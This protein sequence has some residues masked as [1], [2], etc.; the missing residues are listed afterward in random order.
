[1]RNILLSLVFI[2]LLDQSSKA[3]PTEQL[4]DTSAPSWMRNAVVYGIK[5]SGFTDSGSY[6]SITKKLPELHELGINVIWLQPV[7]KTFQGGQGY[8]VTDFFALRNDLGTG[9]ELKQ[10]IDAAHSFNIKVIFDFVPNHSSL[11]HPFAEDIVARGPSSKYYDYYQHHNDGAPYSSY[12][13]Q[14]STGF[15]YYFWKNLVNLNYNNQQVQ[16]LVTNACRYWVTQYDIDGYR[17]DAVW[18][19]NARAPN[20]MQHLRKELRVLKPDF[21]MLAEDRGSDPEVFKKGF[22]AAYDWTNDTSWVSHWPWQYEHHERKSFTVFNHP[23]VPK[24]VALLKEALFA[25]SQHQDRILRFMENND[26]PR[27][28]ATH[29]LSQTKMAAKLLFA[30]PGIPLI[31]NGQETGVKAHPYSRRPIFL[32]Q[33]TIRQQD[34]FQ[35]FDIYRSLVAQRLVLKPFTSGNIKQIAVRGAAPVVAFKRWEGKDEIVVIINVDS[36]PVNA[37]L[38]PGISRLSTLTDLLTGEHFQ[39]TGNNSFQLPMQGYGV[40]WLTE[41]KEKKKRVNLKKQ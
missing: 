34:S 13:H 8:D 11:H 22:D 9:D 38:P 41:K 6:R 31:Y 18:A 12:Y 5:P 15:I 17:F 25:N 24:R 4:P 33:Y 28:A 26:L 3:S 1:M 35:L 10:L 40:R 7:F 16:Q 2:I 30:L 19:V 37:D 27:F 36:I 32:D 23:S 20:F 29:S 14:D 21:F 39:K